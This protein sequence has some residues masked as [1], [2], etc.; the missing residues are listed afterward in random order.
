MY[1]NIISEET[2]STISKVQ[3]FSLCN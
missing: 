2:F 1:K 3:L